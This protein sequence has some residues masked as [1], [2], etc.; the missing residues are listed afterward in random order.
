M[1]GY[2]P[3]PRSP[4]LES[5]HQMQFSVISRI[6]FFF[7]LFFLQG[8]SQ[9]ILSLT[10]RTILYKYNNAWSVLYQAYVCKE[11]TKNSGKSNKKT[12]EKFNNYINKQET[13]GSNNCVGKYKNV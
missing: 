4:E 9:C 6:P 5:N 1:K 12:N 7:C 2:F 13:K 10:D 8:Y 11:K 3:L